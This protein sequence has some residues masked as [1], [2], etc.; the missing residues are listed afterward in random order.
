MDVNGQN[1][2]KENKGSRANGRKVLLVVSIENPSYARLQRCRAPKKRADG[3][4]GWMA[5]H[6]A[7]RVMWGLK[8]P[9]IKAILATYEGG[10]DWDDDWGGG[11]SI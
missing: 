1:I 8:I 11:S 5:F 2:P 7:R 9:A 6:R 4:P 10:H 3:E